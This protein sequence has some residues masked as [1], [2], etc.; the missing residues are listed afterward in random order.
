LHRL[1]H[2]LP[3][4]P[5]PRH[6]DDR[7]DRPPAAQRLPSSLR[8]IWPM[9][10][11]TQTPVAA[12]T[13]PATATHEATDAATGTPP[14]DEAPARVTIEGNEAAVRVAYRLSELCSIY[15]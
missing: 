4:V 2:L 6:R 12:T 3:P 9:T 8:S 5:G 15:P 11:T 14:R 13:T 7:R 1:R 10:A